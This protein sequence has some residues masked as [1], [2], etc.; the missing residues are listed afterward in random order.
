MSWNQVTVE[1]G[2]SEYLAHSANNKDPQTFSMPY[3]TGLSTGDVFNVGKKSYTAEK[4]VDLAQRGET[5]LV[6]AKEVKNGG[7]SKARGSD[8]NSGS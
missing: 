3:S 2:G 7:K 8:D 6:E 1:F 5:I 4:V